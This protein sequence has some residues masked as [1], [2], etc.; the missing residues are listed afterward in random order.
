MEIL[1]KKDGSKKNTTNIKEL[2]ELLKLTSLGKQLREIKASV[3]EIKKL[4]R[5]EEKDIGSLIVNEFLKKGELLNISNAASIEKLK[6]VPNGTIY[7]NKAKDAVRIKR[8][9]GWDTLKIE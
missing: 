3:E 2:S 4:P 6:S 5:I 1:L 7:Y 9:N 8:K